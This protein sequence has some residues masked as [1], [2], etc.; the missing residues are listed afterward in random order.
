MLIFDPLWCVFW[1]Q[2]GRKIPTQKGPFLDKIPDGSKI[3]IFEKFPKWS[4]INKNGL[5]NK[6]SAI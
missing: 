5:G 4:K 6:K 3:N 2:N 1:V